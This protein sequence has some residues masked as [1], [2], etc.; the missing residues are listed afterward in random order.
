LAG[1]SWANAVG[2][3]HRLAMAMANPCSSV[4][5]NMKVSF[6]KHGRSGT[7]MNSVVLGEL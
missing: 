3:T 6:V 4:L 5:R 2:V 7:A 1:G